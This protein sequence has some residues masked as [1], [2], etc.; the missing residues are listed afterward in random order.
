M[1]NKTFMAF[2]LALALPLIWSPLALSGAKGSGKSAGDT[3]KAELS[4]KGGTTRGLEQADI[5]AKS[6]GEQ[7]REKA[8]EKATTE[9]E[10]K[11]AKSKD[12]K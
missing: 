3:M 6:S 4:D 12:K 5:A 1:R 10:T 2:V 9:E 7:G 11:A 8:K